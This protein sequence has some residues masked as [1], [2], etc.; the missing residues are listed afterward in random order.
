[1]ILLLGVVSG[2]LGCRDDLIKADDTLGDTAER[3]EKN[4][5]PPILDE[6]GE[7]LRNLLNMFPLLSEI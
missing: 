2:L 3:I 5:L 4:L 1:M 7:V 6:S